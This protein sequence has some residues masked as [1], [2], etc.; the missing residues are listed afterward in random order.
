MKLMIKVDSLKLLMNNLT[1]NI[2]KRTKSNISQIAK[3]KENGGDL[4]RDNCK[5]EWK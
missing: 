2:G 5:C 1:L 3:A 4:I